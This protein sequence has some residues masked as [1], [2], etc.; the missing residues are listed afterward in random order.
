[1]RI[2]YHHRIRSKD[3]Q[4]V[5]LEEMVEALRKAGHIVQLV[6]PAAFT[7]A[8]FGH[9]PGILAKAKALAPAGLYEVAELCY[10]IVAFV[11]LYVAFLRFRPDFVYERYN[12]YLLAGV[13]LKEITAAPLVLEV[14]APLAS[15]RSRYGGLAFRRLARAI[16]SWT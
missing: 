16:E 1:M 5:H 12:L 14:N 15:E 13:W 6:G 2:L 3:G 4:A 8:E 11:R 9:E 7:N 10:N